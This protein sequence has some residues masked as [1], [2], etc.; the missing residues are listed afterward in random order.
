M[1]ADG[2]I[3]EISPPEAFRASQNPAVQQFIQGK[4]EGPIHVL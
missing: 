1:L 3:E 2:V 4:S